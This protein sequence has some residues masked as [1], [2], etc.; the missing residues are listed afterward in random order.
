M[1]NTEI[2]KLKGKEKSKR[3]END[4]YKCLVYKMLCEWY[5]SQKISIT[6]L[7]GHCLNIKV[8]NK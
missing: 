4:L 1:A 2:K 8:C 6:Q 5:R 7:Q 3:N